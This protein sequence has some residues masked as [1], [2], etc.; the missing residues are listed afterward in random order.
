MTSPYVGASQ[1][2]ACEVIARAGERAGS[3]GL[4][5]TKTEPELGAGSG[6]DST[7]SR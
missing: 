5:Q 3:D 4:N 1:G 2:A 6:R 7:E